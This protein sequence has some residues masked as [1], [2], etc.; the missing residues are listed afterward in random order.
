MLDGI[1]N[2]RTSVSMIPPVLG[3]PRLLLEADADRDGIYESMIGDTVPPGTPMRVRAEGLL[4][5]GWVEVRANGV[6]LFQGKALLPGKAYAFNAP[7]KAGWVR[8]ILHAPDAR[9]ERRS[10]CNP[11]LGDLTTYCRNR[12]LVLALTS[13][14]YLK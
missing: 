12:V 10:L 5:F 8:A 14:I 1:R 6:Q 9:D 13:P 3:G 4:G 11:L 7:P 2:D